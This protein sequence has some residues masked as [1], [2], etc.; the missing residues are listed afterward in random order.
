MGELRKLLDERLDYEVDGRWH[1]W[2]EYVLDAIVERLEPPEEEERANAPSL[3]IAQM[4]RE[5]V[6][7]MESGA[8]VPLATWADNYGLDLMNEVERRGSPTQQGAVD[9]KPP[10]PR[11]VKGARSKPNEIRA[12]V[13]RD[14]RYV[15]GTWSASPS[16]GGCGCTLE[17][18]HFIATGY[19]HCAPEDKFDP[20]FGL[21]LAHK[22][23]LE[24]LEVALAAGVMHKGSLVS[25]A[26]HHH[27]LY[28]WRKVGG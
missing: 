7:A 2:L 22:R 15:C 3:D 1:D 19:A 26:P 25:K 10:R 8:C 28:Q 21:K 4:R 17:L 6:D 23:A 16:V 24:A 13:K 9:I 12:R 20:E 5:W 27:L 14:A 18:D 11:R